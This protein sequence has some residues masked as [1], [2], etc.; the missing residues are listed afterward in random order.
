MS[1]CVCINIEINEK[2]KDFKNQTR[3]VTK[4]KKSK[5]FKKKSSYSYEMQHN[6]K[7]V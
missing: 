3:Y 7:P 2:N 5:L 6:L 4:E 1:E